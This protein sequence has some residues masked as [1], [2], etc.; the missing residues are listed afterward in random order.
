MST[1]KVKIPAW[2][3]KRE[4]QLRAI[5]DGEAQPISQAVVAVAAEEL[6][7]TARSISSKLRSKS[8]NFEVE[9]AAVAA[10]AKAFSDEEEAELTSFVNANEGQYTFAEIAENVFGEDKTARQVQGK[11]LSLEMSSMVKPTEP[12]VVAAKYTEA[13]TNEIIALI[14][15]GKFVEE[16]AEAMGRPVNSIRGKALSLLKAEGLE[17]PKQRDHK[18]VQAD[19][20]GALGDVSDMTVA[21]VAEAIGKTA[22]GVKTMLTHRGITC[23]DYDGAAKRDKLDKAKAESA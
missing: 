18:E 10:K 20:L 3:E 8:M 12:K 22:R 2:D 6:N 5:V 21:E 23:S 7:T 4:A 17:M 16:I 19:A 15:S 11:L 1:E 13:E 14:K 9:S